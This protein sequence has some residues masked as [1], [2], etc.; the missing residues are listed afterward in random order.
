[1]K[2]LIAFITIF[3]SL[4]AYSQKDITIHKKNKFEISLK[5]DVTKRKSN[6]YYNNDTIDYSNIYRDP[7]FKSINNYLAIHLGIK[8]YLP[9]QLILNAEFRYKLWGFKEYFQVPNLPSSYNQISYGF[10]VTVINLDWSLSLLKRIIVHP[11]FEIRPRLGFTMFHP[12]TTGR[13]SNAY[14]LNIAGANTHYKGQKLKTGYNI[15]TEFNYKLS[16]KLSF[17][18]STLYYSPF[19]NTYNWLH[20]ERI[21][22]SNYPW[23]KW[24]K[25]NDGFYFGLGIDINLH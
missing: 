20:S 14:T 21:N 12:L 7:A 9:H 13:D 10:S 3:I 1:M 6:Q 19:N 25:K 15:G 16:H 4:E 5:L 11:K 24:A 17:T 2:Q 18:F 23:I 8:K 22:G